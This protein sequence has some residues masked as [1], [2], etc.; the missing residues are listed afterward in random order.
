V[1]RAHGREVAPVHGRHRRNRQALANSYHRGICATHA[2]VR[3]LAYQ[4]GHAPHVS[5]HEFGEL[6]TVTEADTNAVEELC[7]GFRAEILVDHVA[8]LGHNRGQDDQR[9]IAV[10]KPVSALDVVGVAPVSQ[11]D[12]DIRVDDDHELRTLPAEP[13]G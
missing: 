13:F 4:L 6:E 3:V 8:G 7:L 2:P 12:K 11:G 9:L 1:A 5:I 10:G